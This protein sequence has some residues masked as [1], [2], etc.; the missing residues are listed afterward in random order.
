MKKIMIT[1]LLAGSYRMGSWQ[2]ILT[3]DVTHYFNNVN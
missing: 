3:N 1:Y 2:R